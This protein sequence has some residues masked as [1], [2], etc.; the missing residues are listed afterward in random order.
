M[1]SKD[2]RKVPLF[3]GTNFSFWKVRM[4]FY[5]ISLGLEVWK[6]FLDGY[7]VPPSPPAD[8]DGRKI[9]ITNAK[10]LNSIIS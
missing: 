9:Y 4:K 10:S 8:Y 5:L 1:G 7:N 6:S 2:T 3:D